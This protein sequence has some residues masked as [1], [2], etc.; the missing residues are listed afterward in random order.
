MT[1][2]V[3]NNNKSG[4]VKG[5]SMLKLKKEDFV[6]EFEG[7]TFPEFS[8]L[9][10]SELTIHQNLLRATFKCSKDALILDV[11]NKIVEASKFIPNINAKENG[12]SFTKTLISQ[13]INAN[14][15]IYLDW[16]RFDDI[17][18]I[19]LEDFSRYFDDI[20]Y[21]EADDI[22][23][24]DDTFRWFALITHYGAISITKV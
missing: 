21:P 12:F 18:C 6:A 3:L 19:E 15:C 24:Y 11:F 10:E 20:W 23:V 1:L 16:H 17:D 9:K 4:L 7:E 5:N 22:Y 8:S 13:G 14:S 2:I